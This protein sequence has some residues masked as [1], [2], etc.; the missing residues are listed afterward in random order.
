MSDKILLFCSKKE[1]DFAVKIIGL[2]FLLAISSA[3]AAPVVFWAPDSIEPGNVI[4][5]Y[6]G[7]LATANVVKVSR[8]A[9]D[10]SNPSPKFK[11]LPALQ[12]SDNSVKFILPTDFTPGIFSAGVSAG[13][14]TSAPV[15]LNRPE[16][17]FCQLTILQPGLKKNEVSPGAAVQIIGKNF[18]LPGDKGAPRVVLKHGDISIP[19]AAANAERFSLLAQLPTN[20]VEGNYELFIHNGFGGD[21][22]WSEPLAITVKNPDAWPETVFNVKDFGAKGDDVTDDTKAIESALAAAEKNGGGTV[23][24]PWGCYRLTNWI[25]IPPRTIVRG[26]GRDSTILKWPAD[27][28][29][30]WSDFTPVAMVGVAPCALEDLTLIARKVDNLFMDSG[31]GAGVPAAVRGKGNG[32]DVFIRRVNFQHW[33][34]AGHPDRDIALWNVSTNRNGRVQPSK[35]NGDGAQIFSINGVTNFE[36]SDCQFQGGQLHIRNVCNARETGNYFGNEM[37]YCWA[38]MGGGAHDLISQSNDIHASSSWGYGSIGMRN[39]YS[40]HNR[41]YNFVRGEREAMTLDI[42]A[43][44]AGDTR[45]NIAWFGSPQKIDGLNL[46]LS[47]IKAKPGEFT[48]LAVMI[49]DGSGAGQYRVI[50][51]NTPTV[52]T[53]EKDWDVPPTT[54]SVLGLWNLMRHMIVYK[55]EGYDC[56]AFSQL[57]GSY[58]DFTVDSCRTERNQG[59]WGQSGWF[60]QF[61]YNDVFYADTYHP[62]IGPHGS[63]PEGNLPFGFVGL[64]DGNLRITKFGSAQYN[65][66]T[67]FVNDVAPRPVP[68]ACG[69]IVKGNDLRYNERIAFPPSADAKPRDTGDVRFVDVIVDDNRIEHSS[70]GVQIGP[71]ARNV[72]IANLHT[73]DVAQPYLLARP[74]KVL[75]IPP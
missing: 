52:F 44:P 38:E 39:V 20:L 4:L 74:E 60:V 67:V 65:R 55:C 22:G 32:H 9:D 69:V 18:L 51:T 46:T 10:A 36:V 61:R 63:N 41:S 30:A 21:A 29:K 11:M 28:P 54:N 47:G 14:E 35:F 56:S 73:N 34:M 42:S 45:S 33:L 50:T 15:I 2:F 68:G 19:L 66:Q 5:L 16:L 75:V 24:F 25:C 64:T 12:P 17:W 71:P 70:V 72:V 13:G 1:H 57:W 26:D 49:L 62:G 8:L 23:Y 7:G 40:A 59:L 43:L 37:G 58:Y 48:G 27:E 6:G 31:F 3:V 53:V